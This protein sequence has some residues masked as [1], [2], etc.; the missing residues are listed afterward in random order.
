MTFHYTQYKNGSIELIQQEV[1]VAEWKKNPTWININS[2]NIEEALTFLHEKNVYLDAKTII[3]EPHKNLGTKKLK[4]GIISN[5]EVSSYDDIYK[6]DYITYIIDQDLIITIMP[7]SSKSS[8]HDDFEG[9]DLN[10]FNSLSEAFF[11]ILSNK[12]MAGSTQNEGIA[13]DR[14]HKLE[15]LLINNP[16][17]LKIT[18]LISCERDTSRLAD[19]IEDQ[20]IGFGTLFTLISPK[21]IG[22][23]KNQYSQFIESFEPLNKAMGR[24][25][26]KAESIR[27]Q[28]TLYQQEKSNRKIN[29]LTI[30]QAIFV[31]LTFLAGIYGMNFKYMPELNFEYGYF[32]L[33]G[34]FIVLATALLAYFYKTG[35][36][37]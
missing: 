4:N 18:D 35:W 15:D 21:I 6:S 5:L 7:N 22:D 3:E 16:D 2:N 32:V 14:I 37:N 19:I 27:L 13:R 24:L 34:V 31:P 23:A 11:Y 17:N 36:F 28:Y 20:N 29:V 9:A 33:W 1:P 26:E 12:I 8:I 10:S 25:E 30:I